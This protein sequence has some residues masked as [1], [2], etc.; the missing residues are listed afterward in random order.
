MHA[1]AVYQFIEKKFD[2]LVPVNLPHVPGRSYFLREIH[3]LD[4]ASRIVHIHERADG[5]IKEVK[6]AVSPRINGNAH[7]PLT[8][9]DNLAAAIDREIRLLEE[10]QGDKAGR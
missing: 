10:V 8:S 6:L 2:N 1:S 3:C 7:L 5:T 4:D 9:L